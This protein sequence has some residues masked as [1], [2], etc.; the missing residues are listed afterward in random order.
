[1]GGPWAESCWLPSPL[2][3]TIQLLPQEQ[4]LPSF[5]H[6]ESTQDTP[7]HAQVSQTHSTQCQ[8]LEDNSSTLDNHSFTDS[9]NTEF[10]NIETVRHIS[11]DSIRDSGIGDSFNQP[12]T[13]FT[14]KKNIP[15][16][17][18]NDLETDQDRSFVDRHI[19]VDSP[20]DLDIE[21][22]LTC[23]TDYM[24]CIND[25]NAKTSETVREN[26]Y[27][28]RHIS[29]TSDSVIT[30]SFNLYE[31]NSISQNAE[32]YHSETVP[33]NTLND[34]HF[35]IESTRNS[36]RETNS[37]LTTD[38]YNSETVADRSTDRHIAVN[39]IDESSNL[40]YSIAQNNNTNSVSYSSETVR[41]KSPKERHISVDSARDSG[42]GEGS[43]LPDTYSM[44]KNENLR[45]LWEP[46]IKHSL[47][48]RLPKNMYYLVT[49][50]RYIF[51]GAEVFYDPDEKYGFSDDDSSSDSD[52]SDSD[53]DDKET[54][55]DKLDKFI[56]S[57]PSE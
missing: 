1:M 50:S 16:I 29:V 39:S 28:N 38:T 34:R 52:D 17:K 3:E 14:D 6:S 35:P 13:Y 2:K 51:P 24:N 5:C 37:N 22:N 11:V 26:S 55:L 15:N 49:P 7:A 30:E 19:S 48:D 31:N 25:S 43:N 8:L 18:S 56:G 44:G 54:D 33:D 42:I 57:K 45:N 21:S 9:Q 40:T 23:S 36:S 27:I 10:Y 41:D 47:A 20:R 46:K 4:L 53:S 12:E 32:T